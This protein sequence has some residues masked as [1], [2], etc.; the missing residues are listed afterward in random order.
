MYPHSTP[1]SNVTTTPLS[2]SISGFCDVAEDYHE[3]EG[4]IVLWTVALLQRSVI[5]FGHSS[6]WLY[7]FNILS[8]AI[9]REPST[10]TVLYKGISKVRISKIQ[11]RVYC[12]SFYYYL[13]MCLLLLILLCACE[14]EHFLPENQK[15]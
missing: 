9:V 10:N 7:Y 2:K 8:L 5:W 3:W 15:I 11:T 12:L 4:E 14:A 6:I 13:G 1:L